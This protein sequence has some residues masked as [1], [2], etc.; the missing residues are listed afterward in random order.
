MNVVHKVIASVFGIGFIKGGGTIA[1][2]L[3]C[4]L[5]L[6]LQPLLEGKWWQILLTVLVIVIGTWSGNVVDAYWGKDSSKVV[7]DEVAGM[8]VTIVLFPIQMK[9]LLAGLVLFRF[10][11][12]AKPLF[13]RRAERLPKG[14]GVMADDVLAGLYAHLVLW[15]I[16]QLNLL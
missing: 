4:V 7:I 1:A 5:C 16:V 10:F 13:I 12:I 14:V 6:L 15:G 2:T 3:C 11:D 9:F 8:M